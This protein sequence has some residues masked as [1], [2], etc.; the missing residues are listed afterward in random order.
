MMKSNCTKC[1]SQFPV[2]FKT[3]KVKKIMKQLE[4]KHSD[5]I[6]QVMSNGK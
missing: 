2:E 5:A 6:N 4:S 3:D 1:Q